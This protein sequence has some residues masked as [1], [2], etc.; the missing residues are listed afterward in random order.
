M[1]WSRWGTMEATLE[2]ERCVWGFFSTHQRDVAD[3]LSGG[4]TLERR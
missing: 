2:E 3:V 4:V 1:R